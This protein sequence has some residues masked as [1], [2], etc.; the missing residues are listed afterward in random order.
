MNKILKRKFVVGL[1]LIIVTTPKVF[2]DDAP[3]YF[4]GGWYY[5]ADSFY[6]N[7]FNQENISQ[8]AF[9]PF[10][11]TDV[12]PFYEKQSL[13]D[14]KNVHEWYSF[15]NKKYTKDQLV[16]ILYGKEKKVITIQGKTAKE[17]AAKTYINFAKSCEKITVSN[18]GYYWD[19]EALIKKRKHNA[20]DLINKGLSLYSKE[21]NASLKL[22]YAY[23]LIR[24]YRYNYQFQTAIEFYNNEVKSN[25][26]KNEVYYY[27]LD[28]IAGCYYKLKNYEKAA[29]LFLKVFDKSIDK[30][31]SAFV[32]YKFCTYKKAEGKSFLTTKEEKANQIFITAIRKFSD[33]MQDLEEITDLGI[34]EDK[35][36]LLAIR[37]INNLE[38]AILDINY[39]RSIFQ[40]EERVADELIALQSYVDRKL[41][42]TPVNLEFWK[43]TD[44]YISFLN[45]D[46]KTAEKKLSLI[47]SK[48]FQEQKESLAKVFEVFSWTTINKENELWLSKFLGKNEKGIIM[49]GPCDIEENQ[50]KFSCNLRGI[51][52]EQVSHLYL[53][54][55]KLAQSYLIHNYLEDLKEIS[56]HDLVDDIIQFIKKED[57]NDFEKSLLVSVE[58]KRF[59]SLIAIAEEAK[60]LMYFRSGDFNIAKPYFTPSENK[61]IPAAI[62]SNNTIECFNCKANTVMEDEVYKASAYSFLN[63]KMNLYDLLDNLQTLERMTQDANT[64][65]WKKKLAY[66]LLG[67]YF[68]N[69]SNTGYYRAYTYY[70]KDRHYNYDLGSKRSDINDVIVKKKTYSFP[71]GGYRNTYNGLAK[72]AKY[73]YQKTIAMSTDNELNARC[74][75][76]IAKCELNEYYNNGW[77]SDYSGYEGDE[78]TK[79]ENSG[80]EALKTKYKNTKFY[81]FIRSKC[82]YF[83]QYD[84][85]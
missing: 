30:K 25:V 73:Y 74:S 63:K 76:M 29:Y 43:L 32:S 38:R 59:Q 1:L 61:N 20:P 14:S 8:K 56:S 11:R 75:Y 17:K 31:K 80:F 60:G 78:F 85:N 22:R 44:A 37:I 50:A 81:D 35:Q 36:E 33:T 58:D 55:N 77:D 52:L 40:V 12:N 83:R 13:V 19:Y 34:A 72:K 68:Y 21:N 79:F 84:A 16:K 67:N 26:A 82:S 28:Q 46:F 4:C 48:K 70:G 2:A 3:N 15:F 47:N 62:F 27:I 7:L 69:A 64:K 23:Q 9:Y 66:Y 71:Y 51:I 54:E 53:K 42:G 18:E 10:L 6:Y 5:D 65:Q 57:K 24:L 39:R 49:L 41:E 45:Q